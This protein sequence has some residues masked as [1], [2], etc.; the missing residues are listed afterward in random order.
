MDLLFTVQRLADARA[1]A[2]PPPPA[3][4]PRISFRERR[5][6]DIARQDARLYEESLLRERPPDPDNARLRALNHRERQRA[7]K[8]TRQQA[9]DAC[10]A[11]LDVSWDPAADV[12]ESD[13]EEDEDDPVVEAHAQ[14]LNAR[15]GRLWAQHEEGIARTTPR[16]VEGFPVRYVEGPPRV[17]RGVRSVR[18]S[19]LGRCKGCEGEGLRCSRVM[20]RRGRWGEVEGCERCRRRGEDCED[21]DGNGKVKG[22]MEV[23][24]GRVVVVERERFAPGMPEKAEW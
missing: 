21:G 14:R 8:H 12:E 15:A 17:Q 10:R 6:Q 4:P 23:V 5:A 1:A 22:R 9:E 24:G 11:L 13:S 7:K 20:V 19:G 3:R 2:R 18:E 16:Y